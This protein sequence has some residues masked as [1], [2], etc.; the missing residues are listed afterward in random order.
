M[1]VQLDRHRILAEVLISSVALDRKDQSLVDILAS[2]EF[3]GKRRWL[4]S[5]FSFPR[6]MISGKE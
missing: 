4:Y 2:V 6:T 3:V 5:I 1:R